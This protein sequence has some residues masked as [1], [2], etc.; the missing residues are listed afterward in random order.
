MDNSNDK[1]KISLLE[2]SNIFQ[3]KTEQYSAEN[4]NENSNNNNKLSLNLFSSNSY[5]LLKHKSKPICSPLIINTTTN[6]NHQSNENLDNLT[7]LNNATNSS[8]NLMKIGGMDSGYASTVDE[9]RF[10]REVRIL[11]FSLIKLIFY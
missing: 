7:V 9:N 8:A 3:F 2:L 1:E 11:I 4:S 6:N 5:D 10:S